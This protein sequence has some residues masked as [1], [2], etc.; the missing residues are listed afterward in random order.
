M[1]DVWINPDVVGGLGDGSSLAN[2]YDAIIA[3]EAA[4]NSDLVTATDQMNFRCTSTGGT[5]DVGYLNVSGWTMNGTYYLQVQSEDT[6]ST[7]YD[8]STY[9]IEANNANGCVQCNSDY[10]R[11]FGIQFQNSGA[12]ARRV[13]QTASDNVR[14]YSCISRADNAYSSA[15]G[16]QMGGTGTSYIKNT[17]VYGYGTDGLTAGILADNGTL[18]CYN[19]TVADVNSNGYVAAGDATLNIKNCVAFN[20]GGTD[21]VNT[22]TIN[23]DYCGWVDGDPGT[24]GI[25]LSSEAGTDLFTDYNNNDYGTKDNSSALYGA[26]NDISGDAN[27]PVTLDVIGT[28]RVQWDIGFNE[29]VASGTAYQKTLTD[30]VGV[31]DSV[32]TAAGYFKTIA[33]SVGITDTLIK[34]AGYTKSISDTVG[35]TDVLAAGIK[36]LVSLADS[37]GITDSISRVVTYIRTI[38]DTVGITDLFSRVANYVRS[39]ADSVGIT[40]LLIAVN[41]VENIY[42]EIESIEIQDYMFNSTNTAEYIGQEIDSED[43]LINNI[44]SEDSV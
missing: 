14:I 38:S 20:I 26:G 10:V 23:A 7:S 1:S 36:Y 2:A 13:F 15:Y 33:D 41:L 22:G 44:T 42:V 30:S 3:A 25:D 4:K 40:D 24:N 27:L 12:S 29:Y 34:A 28:T 11:W 31:T 17:L 19:T 37:V 9:R 18:Y 43:Y 35:I 16:F 5:A 8:T 21:Y 6:L 32:T 39:I